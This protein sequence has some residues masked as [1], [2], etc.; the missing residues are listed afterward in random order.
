MR[1][2]LSLQ[3]YLVSD[4][5]LSLMS[6]MSLHRKMESYSYDSSTPSQAI[7]SVLVLDFCC[8]IRIW[9]LIIACSSTQ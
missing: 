6:L 1:S 2:S 9:K 3:W 7:V 8:R 5:I 4:N